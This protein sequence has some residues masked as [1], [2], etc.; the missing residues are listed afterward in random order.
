MASIRLVEFTALKNRMNSTKTPHTAICVR[1]RR[2]S[3]SFRPMMSTQKIVVNEVSAES[4]L[5]NEAATIPRTNKMG[6][7]AMESSPIVKVLTKF[8][9]RS[10][11]LAGRG[12]PCC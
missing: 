1:L 6:M 11:P 4:A 3:S 10:S 2:R 9:K 12:R 5:E 7:T 8:G